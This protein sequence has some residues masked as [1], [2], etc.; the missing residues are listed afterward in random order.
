MEYADILGN[1]TGFSG[2]VMQQDGNK[3]NQFHFGYGD[4]KQGYGPGDVQLTAGAWQHVAVVCD[5]EKAFGYI[6]GV[7]KS[8]GSSK[9]A[10]APNLSMTFRL[11][12]GYGEKRFFKGLLS[13]VRIYRTAL[14]PAEVQKVMKE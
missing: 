7:E 8:Q 13:D 10:F 4:G 1:H 11:G 14:S 2:L 6:N 5:G 12:Q 3:T 9:G